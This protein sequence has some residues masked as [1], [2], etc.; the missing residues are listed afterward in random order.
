MFADVEPQTDNLPPPGPYSSGR[1]IDE[2]KRRLIEIQDTLK[3]LVS[4]IDTQIAKLSN[5]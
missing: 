4:E 3:D 5:P 2:A 1:D